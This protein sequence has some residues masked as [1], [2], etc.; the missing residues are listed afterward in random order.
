MRRT[1]LLF[2]LLAIAMIPFGD[3]AI[4]T[5]DPWNELSRLG[6]GLLT[7][8]LPDW[9]LLD[10]VL[11][12]LSFA[13]QGVALGVLGGFLLSL[14]YRWSGI[15]AF[16]S[17]LRSIHELF[18][19]LLL[20]QLFGLTPFAGVLA[21]ALPYA[22]TFA[23]IYGE[24]YE[25][26]NP[27]PWQAVSTGTVSLV[28]F[29][30]T[31]LPQ[32]YRAMALYSAYR[33]ECG[34]RS[35]IVLGFIGLPTL[36]YY[37]ETAVRQGQ[38]SDAALYFYALIGVIVTLRF[39]LRR[40]L[41]PFY[42]VAALIWLPPV[43]SVDLDFLIQFVTRDLVPAPWRQ[44]GD[45]WP[46][47]ADLLSTQMLPGL[48]QTLVLGFMAFAVTGVLTL[49]LFPSVSPLFGRPAS[50]AVGHVVLVLLRSTPEYLLA[51]LGLILWG[52]SLLPGIA[53][54]SLHNAGIIAHLVGRYTQDLRLRE[55]AVRGVRRYT[56]E[57]LPRVYRQFLAFA[58]YRFEIILRETATLGILG[59]P[60]LG[61]Y[62][63]SA[64]NEFR[65]DRA[66]LLL[67]AAAGLNMAVD[68][69]ARALRMRLHLRNQPEVL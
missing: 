62:I 57:V 31:V 47:L 17:F 21:L 55:D 25:E 5:R 32:S 6:W 2:V 44:G 14:G 24:L 28:G 12:T 1:S 66:L 18:W 36:G 50:R 65:F 40:T 56:Y 11:T 16:A 61:F 69:L 19:A 26:A 33:F 68:T 15:R 35:S 37:L 45:L 52:P 53:A 58:L 42:L 63:D 20:I 48:G 3:F 22:G 30:Y 41:L 49:L 27:G 54:L 13:L 9:T 34:I 64:F 23:K 67:L 7:P 60:T 59:L 46:W 51:F 39:W 4:T 8:A 43:W 38:Y 29:F 10:A